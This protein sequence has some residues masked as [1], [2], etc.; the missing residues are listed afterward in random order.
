MQRSN[1]K[2]DNVQG[3]SSRVRLDHVISFS[4]AI[5]A[6]S[7]TFMALSI[8]IPNLSSD[9]TQAELINKILHLRPQFEIYA[10]SFLIIGIY[11]ISYHQILNHTRA[12]HS[13]L[14]WVNL[15]FLF[16]ITLISFATSLE[17]VYPLYHIVFL[18]Y[19]IIISI[20]GSLLALIW[21]HASKDRLLID[22]NMSPL[23]IRAISL[24]AITPPL[25]F[26]SSIAI[27]FID[28]QI[29]QYFWIL[30]VPAKV[31]IQRKY[32]Y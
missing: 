2:L 29:A 22:K 18:L 25:I 21:L 26:A 6:F 15:A 8:R 13:I 19:A 11:W 17:T 32:R 30:I 31:I 4:D 20:T 1:S 28:I 12:S 9:L 24:Q 10:I 27:S 7:I 5:F 3:M 16:F 14:I 23:H